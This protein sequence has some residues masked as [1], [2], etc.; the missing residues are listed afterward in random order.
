VVYSQ[1]RYVLE[2]TCQPRGR[3][4]WCPQSSS[5]ERWDVSY[6]PF[7]QVI[8]LRIHPPHPGYLKFQEGMGEERRDLHYLLSTADTLSNFWLVWTCGI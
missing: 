6:A 7:C 4:R 5:A 2:E 3:L 8:K 1:T